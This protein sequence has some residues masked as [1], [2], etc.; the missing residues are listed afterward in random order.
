MFEYYS[1]HY[2]QNGVNF[3]P[4]STI[5]MC[6]FTLDGEVD[7][8][9]TDEDIEQII[10]KI[11]Y[12]KLQMI[13]DFSEGNIYDCCKNCTCL[14]KRP[15]GQQV[16]QITSVTLNHFMVCNLKCVHCGYAKKMETD[17]LL[18]TDHKEVLNIIK[19]LLESNV[20]S[21]NVSF[22][23]GGGEPSLSKGLIDIVQFCIDNKYKMHIN[24]NCANYVETFAQGVNEGIIDLTL[25]PD[26]GSRDVYKSIKG[27]DYFEKVW[28]NIEKYMKSCQAGVKVKFILQEGNIQ[29]IV[30][31]VDMCV[32]TK[33]RE[34]I[35]NLDLN[36]K[37]ENQGDYI[38][39]INKFRTLSEMKSIIVYKGPFI[40]NDVW[41]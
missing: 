30:N 13:K 18:D 19:K 16:R 17:R 39:Y 22:D 28:K 14:V 6:C 3:Y 25:T 2:I 24:S 15:W 26:A 7:V 40:P 11:F 10:R 9:K 23:V 41:I 37:K 8:C 29:D 32:N 1:C 36:I 31:M 38:N 34:V 35:L 33:V 20:V 27:A 5:K 4:N 12:K 21:Q